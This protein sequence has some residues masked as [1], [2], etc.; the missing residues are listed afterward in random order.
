MTVHIVTPGVVAKAGSVYTAALTNVIGQPPGVDEYFPNPKSA[1]EATK[2]ATFK[3]EMVGARG[4]L[5]VGQDTTLTT[6]N[7]DWF[8]VRASGDIREAFVTFDADG[9][10]PA[11]VKWNAAGAPGKAS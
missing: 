11:E 10:G 3:A 1:A 4:M 9:V 6:S 8:G 5:V 2:T 7:D